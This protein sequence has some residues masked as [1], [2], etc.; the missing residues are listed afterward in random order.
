MAIPRWLENTFLDVVDRLYACIPQK[1]PPINKLKQVRIVAHRGAHDKQHLENT[2]QAFDQ[3]IELGLWGIEFDIR[4]T[5]DL[6]PVVHHDACCNRVF[7]KDVVISEVSFFELHQAIPEIPTLEEVVEHYGKKIHL[8][9]EIK[10]EPYSHPDKQNEILKHIMLPLEPVKDYCFI[11]L[12]PIMFDFAK[13][14]PSEAFF[15]IAAIRSKP[16]A[17]LCIEKNYGGLLG[18]YFFVGNKLIRELQ[19]HGRQVGFGFISSKNSL[20][21]EINRGIDWVY[22]NNPKL[23]VAILQ[24]FKHK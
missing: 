10:E 13:F 18:H 24:K 22:T 20:Y 2:F 23:L 7:K 9:I 14:A 8:M 4:W 16:F 6:V 21:R 5:K 1:K 17:K 15:P 11:S 12:V 19:S 3:A